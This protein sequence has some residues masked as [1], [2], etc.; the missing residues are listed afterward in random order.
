MK[1][2][3]GG[4]VLQSVLSKTTF[5]GLKSWDWSGR[6]LF[7]RETTESRQKGGGE[8]YRRWGGFKDV[9]GE[10]V[11]RYVSPPKGPF[12]TKN[13]YGKQVHYG[14]KKPLRQ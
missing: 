9:F 13:S 7:L 4:N 2:G 3:G 5:G 6:C 8:T 14:D 1:F 10:G 12:L 11:L